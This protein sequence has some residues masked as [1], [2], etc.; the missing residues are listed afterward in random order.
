M[1]RPLF[2]EILQI[3]VIKNFWNIISLFTRWN[4]FFLLSLFLVVIFTL[5]IVKLKCNDDT[6]REGRRK[7]NRNLIQSKYFH[8]CW[9]LDVDLENNVKNSKKFYLNCCDF[10]LRWNFSSDWLFSKSLNSVFFI[11]WCVK[12]NSE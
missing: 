2:N 9:Y 11:F 10:F 4:S 7:R 8:Q 5:I 12:R 6:R 3:F 1:C